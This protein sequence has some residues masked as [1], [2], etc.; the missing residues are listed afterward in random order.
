MKRLFQVKQLVI[1]NLRHEHERR[2]VNSVIIQN[3]RLVTAAPFNPITNRISTINQFTR[4]GGASAVRE[5]GHFEVRKSSSQVTPYQPFLPSCIT[6][7]EFYSIFGM[8]KCG[9]EP[10][11]YIGAFGG[12]WPYTCVAVNEEHLDSQDFCTYR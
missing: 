9:F 1:I 12:V 10:I 7:I 6:V 2:K 5:P 8:K 4:S 11:G 3:C